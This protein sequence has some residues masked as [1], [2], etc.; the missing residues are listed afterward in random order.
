MTPT[1]KE[2]KIVYGKV[3]YIP[4]NMLLDSG[5]NKTVVTDKLVK[6]DQYLPDKVQM[7]GVNGVIVARS[8]AKIWLILYT[9]GGS[10]CGRFSR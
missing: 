7:T 4:C 5:A 10:S 6:P 3:G 9:S 1:P 8:K 2:P